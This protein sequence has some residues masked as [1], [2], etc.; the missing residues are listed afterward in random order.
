MEMTTFG[1][2]AA[3][4]G[5]LFQIRYALLLLLRAIRDIGPTV[6]L[7]LE[8]TDDI[9]IGTDS[10]LN[11]L[12]QTKHH[13]GAEEGR[14]V[15]LSNASSDLWKTIRVWSEG[16]R[17]DTIR[18]PDVHLYLVS[19]ATAAPGSAAGLLRPTERDPE[20]AL[21]ALK[22]TADTSRAEAN[23]RAYEAFKLLDASQQRALVHAIRVLDG[24]AGISDLDSLLARELS[25]NVPASMMERV[26]TKLEGWWGRRVIAH[27]GAAPFDRITGLEVTAYLHDLQRQLRDDTL[28]IDDDLLELVELN[29]SDH[30]SRVFVRQLRLIGLR[31]PGILSAIEDYYKAFE[32]RSRWTREDLLYLGELAQYERRLIDE[33]RHAFAL[34]ESSCPE[35]EDGRCAAGLDLYADISQRPIPIRQECNDPF[36][37][38]GSLH[39][40]ADD[41]R[42]GWHVEFVARLREIVSREEKVS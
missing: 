42:I 40:L 38:R 10:N 12:V 31:H 21:R 25:T 20:E 18:L 9:E 1:V 22:A 29:V 2:P 33:W 23:Q 16:I 13:G 11:S 24:S 5:H 30:D 28:P 15:S 6:E 4:L 36:I 17:N 32:Q 19:T 27:L 14:Q 41:L 39:M 8:R 37:A 35:D 34:M 26:L 7:G 3:T